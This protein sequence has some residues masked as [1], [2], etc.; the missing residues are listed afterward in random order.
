MNARDMKS[1]RRGKYAGLALM[2]ALSG[3][4]SVA[5]AN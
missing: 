2:C 1:G 5:G 4:F 3:L